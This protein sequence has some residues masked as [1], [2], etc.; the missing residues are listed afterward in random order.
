MS[1]KNIRYS[2]NTVAA[3]IAATQPKENYTL[4]P[5]EF[6]AQPPEQPYIFTMVGNIP[7][8][9]PNPNYRGGVAK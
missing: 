1:P 7:I 3:A 8:M 9:R 2:K 4:T 6:R 5:E